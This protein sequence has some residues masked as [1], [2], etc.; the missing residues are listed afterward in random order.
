MKT[1]EELKMPRYKVIADYPNN[2][3]SVNEII[4]LEKYSGGY[5]YRW[6]EDW[7]MDNIDESELKE[8]P[9]LFKKL[10]WW[11]EREISDLPEYVINT[12]SLPKTIMQVNWAVEVDDYGKEGLFAIN[13]GRLYPKGLLPATLSEYTTYISQTKP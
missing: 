12:S 8:Y 6:A 2:R 11:E 7:G 4:N 10:E 5:R 3:F 1:V 13:G 9:H